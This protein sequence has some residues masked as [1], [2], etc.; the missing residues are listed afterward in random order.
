MTEELC[1]D[2]GSND[3]VQ[4]GLCAA[5]EAEN[6]VYC[7]VCQEQLHID[8]A[9]NHRHLFFSEH[10]E[11]YGTGG[12]DMDDGA[13]EEIRASLFVLFE[14]LGRDVILALA[15]TIKN[16]HMGYDALHTVT[17]LVVGPSILFCYLDG[18]PD[19]KGGYHLLSCGNRFTDNLSD[20][21]EEAMKYGVCWLFGLDNEETEDANRQTIAWIEEYLNG[22]A[23][24]L[25][26]LQA[27]A[28]GTNL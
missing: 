3:D 27:Y 6:Y 21:D 10:G 16:N 13:L 11:W 28:E 18:E 25:S 14:K 22:H 8:S 12:T 26:G 5:C 20:D 2:C 23:A 7:T 1:R 9:Y 17:G 15:R 19:G 24:Y 4:G